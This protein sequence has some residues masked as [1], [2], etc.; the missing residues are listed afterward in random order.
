MKIMHVTGEHAG[1]LEEHTPENARRLLVIGSARVPTADEL[2]SAEE[3][4]AEPEPKPE[5]VKAT[6]KRG[7]RK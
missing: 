6:A 7:S 3:V 2:K 5:P 1:K 4:K